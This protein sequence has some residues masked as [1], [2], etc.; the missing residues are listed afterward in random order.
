M[1]LKLDLFNKKK[2]CGTI[3]IETKYINGKAPKQDVTRMSAPIDVPQD[4][5]VAA[6]YKG[7]SSVKYSESQ[8]I[9]SGIKAF[10]RLKIEEHQ[11]NVIHTRIQKLARDEAKVKKRIDVALKRTDFVNTIQNQRK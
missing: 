7:L 9:T 10:V 2:K 6:L 1:N 11:K 3:I 4:Q 5:Q 8:S